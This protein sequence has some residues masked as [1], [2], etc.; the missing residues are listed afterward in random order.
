MRVEVRLRTVR[1]FE[2]T[3]PTLR[4]PTEFTLGFVYFISVRGLNA[5]PEITI[6]DAI[7]TS[8]RVDE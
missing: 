6:S 1:V 3:M 8:K 5:A 4:S 2:F 7:V